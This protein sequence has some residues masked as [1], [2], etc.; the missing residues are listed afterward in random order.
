MQ[1]TRDKLENRQV[2]IYF[3]AVALAALA[4]FALPGTVALEAA[5][6]PALAL[7]LF[8]TFLQVPLAELGRSFTN[9][10]FL[11]ALLATNFAAI[12]LLVAGLLPLVPGDPLVRLGVLLVLLAPCID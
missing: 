3:G 5:V 12:P 6:N 11:A 7:M 9:T 10:R 2:A 1:N 4:A 8:V